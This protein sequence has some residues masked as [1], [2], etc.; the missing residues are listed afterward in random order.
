MVRF[1]GRDSCT[2]GTGWASASPG[3]SKGTLMRLLATCLILGAAAV[4]ASAQPFTNA[5]TSLANYTVADSTPRK[6]CESLAAFKGDGIVSI[7]ARVVPATADT[8]QHC[9]VTGVITPEV[10]FEVNLPDRWNRRFYMTGNGGLAGDALDGP[11]N[12]GSDRRLEQRLRARADQYRA[13]RAKGAERLVHPQ[14]PAESHRLR[15]PG[16]A[17]HRRDGEEDRDRL[18]RAA[19]PVLV[20]EL[21]LERRPAGS[22]RGAALPRRLRRHRRQR[23]LGRS[24]RVHHRRDVEPEGADRRARLARRSCSS[25]RRR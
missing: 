19:D 13:R 1:N 14:Q 24:D 12:A 4:P 20:L 25:S 9:R 7:N 16:R 2:D 10:A 11:T 22:A 5:K 6:S 3:R 17:R 8:P 21:L 15:V 23:A 18:L